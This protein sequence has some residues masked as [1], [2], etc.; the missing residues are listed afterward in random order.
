RSLVAQLRPS[1]VS[2]IGLR[3]ALSKLESATH[4]QT[5]VKFETAIADAVDD[6]E[7]ELAEDIYQVFAEAVHNAVKHS[8]ADL[9]ALGIRCEEGGM[10]DMHITDNG[11]PSTVPEVDGNSLLGGNGLSFMRQRVERWGGEF[12]AS[13]GG[14]SGGTTIRAQVPRRLQLDDK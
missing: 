12:E 4:R 2:G 6:I 1:A 5:G 10:I 8:S 13:I 3:E 14:D 11:G 7:G 9:I